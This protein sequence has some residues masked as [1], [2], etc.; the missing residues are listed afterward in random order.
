MIS[1]SWMIRYDILPWKN[2]SLHPILPMFV[3][4]VFVLP[5]FVDGTAFGSKSGPTSSATVFWTVFELSKA[6]RALFFKSTRAGPSGP[7]CRSCIWRDFPFTGSEIWTSKY[8]QDIKKDYIIFQ[9]KIKT[10]PYFNQ[11]PI[12]FLKIVSIR[13]T[14]W[15]FPSSRRALPFAGNKEIAAKMVMKRMLICRAICGFIKK[16]CYILKDLVR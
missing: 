3:L 12:K 15:W 16:C 11:E 10:L 5:L 2:V 14:L 1:S 13:L 7:G 4:P 8:F 6:L 9:D